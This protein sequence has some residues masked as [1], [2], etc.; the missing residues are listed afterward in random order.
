MAEQKNVRRVLA[1][2]QRE[3]NVPKDQYNS[4]G[5]YKFRN[6]E[7][8]NLA[9]KP[10]C[11]KYEC[12]YYLTDDIVFIEGRFYLKATATFYAF[13]CD[14]EVSVTSWAREANEKKGMDEAQV[15]GLSSS[16]A[17]K[18]AMCGL[19][20]I[21]SGEEV[22]GMDNR[23]SES[24][25]K[26]QTSRGSTTTQRGSQSSRKPAP[27]KPAAASGDDFLIN[28][29]KFA[30]MKSKTVDDVIAALNKTKAMQALGVVEGTLE[31]SEEQTACAANILANWIAKS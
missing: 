1:E 22:D 24:R 18:Y 12:G 13:G 27:Q 26:A 9:L 23:G 11:E 31:Y 7:S 30:E 8:I 4:F 15:T 21:D 2:V 25:S 14:E 16:Y 5:K 29:T 20:A 3:L 17:R 6:L 10:L 28:L 19:F